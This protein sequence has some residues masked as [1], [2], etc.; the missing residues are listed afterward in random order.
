MVLQEEEV[1]ELQMYFSM[2]FFLVIYI[3]TYVST[4]A[5]NIRK[6]F[7][8]KSLVLSFV[9]VFY[10]SCVNSPCPSLHNTTGWL[11][12]CE[13]EPLFFII[14]KDAL[15]RTLFNAPSSNMRS[16]STRTPTRYSLLEN[17]L[18]S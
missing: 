9:M 15:S 11:L 1:P 16:A 14:A 4:G 10:C 5:I 8:T 2:V 18:V 12:L 13:C 17:H 3:Y 7:C 6:H